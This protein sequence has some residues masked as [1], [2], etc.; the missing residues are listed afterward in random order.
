MSWVLPVS[1]RT[2]HAG[3]EAYLLDHP[4]GEYL[5]S[6]AARCPDGVDVALGLVA[7]AVVCPVG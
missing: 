7:G 3:L 2:A 4:E 5:P 1:N 6:R